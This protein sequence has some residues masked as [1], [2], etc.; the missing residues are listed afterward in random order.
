MS[1]QHIERIVDQLL[2]KMWEKNFH[3]SLKTI[4]SR[5]TQAKNWQ[6][7]WKI[8]RVQLLHPIIGPY[9]IG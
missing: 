4:I 1:Q 2:A 3:T 6:F 5:S 9:I 8:G 7:W